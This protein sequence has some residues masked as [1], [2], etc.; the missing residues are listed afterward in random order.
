MAPVAAVAIVLVIKTVPTSRDPEAPR[1]DIAGL[2]LSTVALATPVYT[3]IEAPGR[4]WSNATTLAGFAAAAIPLAVF[5][6]WER[7]VAQPMLDVRLF[8]NLRFS[9][10]SGSLDGRLLRP[11]RVRRHDHDVLPIHAGLQPS[12]DGHTHSAGGNQPGRCV[13]PR[14]QSGRAG[15]AR[16]APSCRRSATPA[17][18][19]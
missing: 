5:V 10:A 1:L 9:A 17:R 18:Q 6:A 7:R 2:V 15:R 8:T 11:L 4:G 12:L 16:L 3:I 14:D 13:D 19:Q